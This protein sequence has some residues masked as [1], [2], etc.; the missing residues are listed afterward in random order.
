MRN[1]FFLL[2]AALLTTAGP[3]AAQ[4][5]ESSLTEAAEAMTQTAETQAALTPAEALQMLK[6]GNERFVLGERLD[7][8]YPDQVAATAAGQYPYGVVLSCIDSRVPPELV[9]DVG[10]G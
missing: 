4:L 6:S 7:R 3:A 2:L 1:H 10:L 5:S 9:F 8:D